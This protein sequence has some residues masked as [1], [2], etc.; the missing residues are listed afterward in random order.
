M[1]KPKILIVDDEDDFH[2]ILRQILEPAGYEVIS[3]ADGVAGLAEMRRSRPDLMLLDVNM[4]L[5]DGYGVCKEVRADEEFA[6]LPI[7]M[8]T[9]RHQDAEV[10]KGLALGADDYLAKPFD[11]AELMTRIRNLLRRA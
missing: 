2:D 1:K 11:P 4:P 7:L 9:I 3:A 8:L 10:T 6:D 5:K